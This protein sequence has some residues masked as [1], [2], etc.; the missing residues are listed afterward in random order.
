M[1]EVEVR[2]DDV[3]DVGRREPYLR[4][5]TGDVIVLGELDR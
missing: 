3:I 5:L 2:L 4:Q 1:V